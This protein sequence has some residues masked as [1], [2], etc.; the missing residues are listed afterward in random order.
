MEK[1][2]KKGMFSKIESRE[3]ALKVVKDTSLAFYCIAGLTAVLA[4]LLGLSSLV[5]AVLFS[6]FAFLLRQFTSRVAAVVLVVLATGGLIVT[7]IN[8]FGGGE[9]GNNL[10]VALILFWAGLRAVEA[11]FKLHGRFAAVDLGDPQS[12]IPVEEE[13]A[14]TPNTQLNQ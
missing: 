8:R 9:G 6:V 14:T 12:T 7:G 11:T 10:I 3:D 2:K 13:T 4:F 1:K 5:D